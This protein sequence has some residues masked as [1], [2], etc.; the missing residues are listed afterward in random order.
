[1]PEP[2]IGLTMIQ[3]PDIHADS[4]TVDA[5]VSLTSR[6]G[7]VLPPEMETPVVIG[8]SARG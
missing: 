5:F 4:V 2:M 7:E 3:P 8:S 1:M 6:V